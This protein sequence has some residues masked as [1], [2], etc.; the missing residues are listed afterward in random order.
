VDRAKDVNKYSRCILVLGINFWSPSPHPTLH[1]TIAPTSLHPRITLASS[2]PNLSNHIHP[3]H[4]PF[5]PQLS[6]CFTPFLRLSP[7]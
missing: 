7:L 3:F 1:S 4:L 5:H 2:S 6:T